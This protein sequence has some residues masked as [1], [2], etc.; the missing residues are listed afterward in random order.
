MNGITDSLDMILSK[1][2]GWCR[3]RK[4]V[5]LNY[6]GELKVITRFLITNNRESHRQIGRCHTDGFEE[7]K[8][9]LEPRNSDDF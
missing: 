6:P 3:T 8:S 7:G 1:L 9:S 4:L 5:S 2:Q